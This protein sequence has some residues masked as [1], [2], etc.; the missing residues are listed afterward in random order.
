MDYKRLKKE[1][2]LQ[3]THTVAKGLLG[4]YIVRNN[5]ALEITETESYIGSIDK[6]CHAYGGRRTARTEPLFAEGGIFYIYLIYGMYCCL[7]VISEGKDVPCG[8]LIRGA[9][10]AEGY[11]EVSKN[12]YNKPYGLLSPYQKK[13][14]LNGPGKVCMGLGIDRSQNGISCLSDKLFIAEGKDVEVIKTG[15]RIGIDYAE[16]AKDFLWRYYKG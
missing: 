16:E 7:N 14:I 2:Y 10:I 3:D 8:V 11:D 15:K 9:E 12:R 4:K 6:A 13:N 1:F 5:I